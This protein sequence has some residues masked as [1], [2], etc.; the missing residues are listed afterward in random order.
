MD[1]K[2]KCFECGK[3]LS[4]SGSI[5]S[6]A[7]RGEVRGDTSVYI[8]LDCFNNI[9]TAHKKEGVKKYFLEILYQTFR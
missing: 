1:N 8:C 7:Y 3:V 4:S 5:R 2:C 9:L 6:R